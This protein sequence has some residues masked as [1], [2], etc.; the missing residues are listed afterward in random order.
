LRETCENMQKKESS[1]KERNMGRPKL[2]LRGRR[3]NWS[4]LIKRYEAREETGLTL[5]P[6]KKRKSESDS[7]KTG[8]R[9]TYWGGGKV[10]NWTW[11]G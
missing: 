7:R 10:E 6:K 9:Y 4:A 5:L 11:G 1:S 3:G 8:G 2:V